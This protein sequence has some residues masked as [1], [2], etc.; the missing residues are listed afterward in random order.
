MSSPILFD[1]G[2][3]FNEFDVVPAVFP[4]VQ[5]NLRLFGAR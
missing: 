5:V 4:E 2:L 3:C 1:Q